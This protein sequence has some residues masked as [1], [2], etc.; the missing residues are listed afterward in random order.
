MGS[1][2]VTCRAVTLLVAIVC[3]GEWLGAQTGTVPSPA[4]PREL[5]VAVGG[6]H[7][8]VRDELIS[9]QKYAGGS[10][11]WA[12]GWQNGNGRSS[13]VFTLDLA[14]GN[15]SNHSVSAQLLAGS[16]RLAWTYPLGQ[17]SLLGQQLLFCLGPS[18]GLTLYSRT[19]NIARGGATF[20]DA[21]SLAGLIVLGPRCDL[22]YRPRERLRADL[23]LDA[24]ALALGGKLIDLRE[25][26]SSMVKILA[27]WQGFDAVGE[28]ALSYLLA[29]RLVVRAGYR[30]HVLRLSAWD[31]LLLATDTVYCGIGVRL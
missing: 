29:P 1:F 3:V 26:K 31:F 8:A 5:S 4:G 14:A 13:S 10:W 9:R 16:L 30:L 28:M 12:I 2:K 20:F 17:C 19:Q 27:P 7:H 23:T 25:D 6:S 18:S 15:V 11:W 22:S 21:Y 24:N